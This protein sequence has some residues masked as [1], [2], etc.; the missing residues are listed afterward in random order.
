MSVNEFKRQIM[1]ITSR[2]YHIFAFFDITKQLKSIIN[3]FFLN[4]LV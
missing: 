1:Q 2:T 4:H 3:L